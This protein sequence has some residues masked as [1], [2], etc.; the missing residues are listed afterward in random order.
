VWNVEYDI[1]YDL[2]YLFIGEIKIVK[3]KDHLRKEH[4]HRGEFKRELHALELIE[5]EEINLRLKI[6]IW[7]VDDRVLKDK[8][9]TSRPIF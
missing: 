7:N 3:G 1:N 9:H 2:V 8:D 4:A 5:E 6:E